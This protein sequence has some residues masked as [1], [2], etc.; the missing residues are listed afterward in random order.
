MNNVQCVI[1]WTYSKRFP[2]E[3]SKILLTLLANLNISVFFLLCFR[4]QSA[5]L[6]GGTAYS[7]SRI[8]GATRHCCCADMN[9]AGFGEKIAY[10]RDVY[11]PL[12]MS[13]TA[14]FLGYVSNQITE[15]EWKK[16]MFCLRLWRQWRTGVD[17]HALVMHSAGHPLLQ[18][19][20]L[21]LPFRLS[22][23]QFISLHHHCKET[24]CIMAGEGPG[25]S[26]SVLEVLWSMCP[27]HR[28]CSSR[29]AL[30]CAQEEGEGWATKHQAVPTQPCLG[31]THQRP[32][33]L[34]EGGDAA[35]SLEMLW[36]LF[37]S[38]PSLCHSHAATKSHRA[39]LRSV[40]KT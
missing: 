15:V 18:I 8:T 38:L 3:T 25:F 36:G 32:K 27:W 34:Q 33:W 29:G 31:R 21:S 39:F 37:T 1:C 10:R 2:T 13:Q 40:L 6:L 35:P 14:T 22:S 16:G 11:T 7:S 26:Q 23:L 9:Q 20:P 24:N 30:P 4:E 12:H 17:A 5:S 28:W 19:G